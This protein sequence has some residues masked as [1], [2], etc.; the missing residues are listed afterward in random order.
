[1]RMSFGKCVIVA[2]LCIGMTNLISGLPARAGTTGSIQGHVTDEANHGL[3]GV[4]VTAASPSG[5]F[6]T[7]SDTG[8][9]Y[10]LTGVPV[11]TYT[12]GFSKD[13]YQSSAIPGI[14]VV[15]DQPSRVNGHMSTG[16][17][18]LGRVTVR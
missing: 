7:T 6:S 15:Q 4:G 10:S 1:M 14:T 18:S 5:H 9:F 13:G 3:A 11:D 2:L 8:G 12:V 16:V 17:K